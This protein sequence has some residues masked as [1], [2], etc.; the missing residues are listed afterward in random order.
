VLA[1]AGFAKTATLFDQIARG[2]KGAQ[3][4]ALFW[5]EYGITGLGF[6]YEEKQAS[7]ELSLALGELVTA[8]FEVV[9]LATAAQRADAH[10]RNVISQG[11][12]I[13]ADSETIRKL[14]AAKA[15]AQKTLPSAPSATSRWSNTAPSSISPRATPTSRRS[16]TTTRPASSAPPPVSP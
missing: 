10:T 6:S 8:H 11:A 16:P 5:S 4:Q 14:A 3:E 15:T 12:S 9:Q 2:L 7:F 1:Y 13:L